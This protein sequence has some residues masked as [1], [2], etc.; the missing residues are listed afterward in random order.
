MLQILDIIF[1]RSKFS[2]ITD[3]PKPRRSTDEFKTA[4]LSDTLITQTQ[5]RKRKTKKNSVLVLT[6]LHSQ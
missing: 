3:A 6:S 4:P 2:D 1:K 5:R